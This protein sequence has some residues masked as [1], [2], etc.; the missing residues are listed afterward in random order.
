MKGTKDTGKGEKR[1]VK[2]GKKRPTKVSM[3]EQSPKQRI[4]NFDEVP[5]GYTEEMAMEEANRCLQCKKPECIKGCPV[6]INIPEFV[7]YIAEGQYDASIRSLKDQNSLPAVCGRVCPQETQCE[8]FCIVGKKNE[9]VAIGRL[10]RFGADWERA[11]GVAPPDQIPSN[12]HKVAIIGAGPAGLTCAGDLAKSGYQVTIYESLHV[13]GGVLVYGIPQFRLPKE[14]VFAEV[15]YIKDLGVDLQLNMV[16]GKVQNLQELFDQGYEAVFIGTGAGLPMFMRIPGEDLNGV[17]SANEYL[18]RI[19]LMK[20]YKFPEW[21]T[22]VSVGK[23]VAVI[24]GGNVA[25]DAARCSLRLPGVEEVHIVY[26]R[27]S[28]EMPAR[29]EETEH[30]KEEGV[31]IDVLTNPIQ[32]IGEGGWVKK[33]ELVK[34]ELGEP[35]D[36]G[37]RRPIPIEG[38]NYFMDVDTVVVAIGQRPSPIVPLTAP[39]LKTRANG[40]VV[41]DEETCATSI[42]GVFAGGDVATGA[43]TV[44]SAMGAGKRAAASIHEYIL[45]L[46]K[47]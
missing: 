14:I 8:A 28:E 26:R 41:T 35:D 30:A 11:K 15:D 46:Q 7:K 33:A 21:D 44:I 38:S 20:A 27:S 13:P 4:K 39:D 29:H 1:A 23:R 5:H 9:P 10:E 43:A 17:Y 22:P 40:T 24:G 31:I 6:N 3:P 42:P 45:T 32:Y 37:R 47:N 36:S 16:V 12:G 2:K 25:M 19:N 34:Q 18:T